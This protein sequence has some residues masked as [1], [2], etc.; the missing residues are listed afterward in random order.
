SPG[1]PDGR[2]EGPGG[3]P[4]MGPSGGFV[5]EK[6]GEAVWSNYPVSDVPRPGLR[7]GNL[8][9]AQRD[10]ATHALQV[11]LSP[12]GYQ[13]VLDI[14]G[15]DQALSDSGTPFASGTAAYTIGI[16]GNPSTTTPWM[17]EFGG[18]HLALNI[19][20]AGK[21]GVITP[22]LT[23]AQPS[24]YT[25]NG[26]TVRVLAQEND[27]A[28]AL[29]NALD[30]TQRNQ[31]ILN[32]RVNDLVLGPG[33]AGVTIQPEGLKASAL[34]EPQRA[35]LLA[36]ISEWAGIINEAYATPRMAEIKAGLDDTYFAWSG[37]ATHEPGKNGSAYYRIQGPKLVIEFSPQGVGGDLTMHVHTMYR[38]PTNDYG[39]KF[40]NIQ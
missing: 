38:D 22:T 10:A 9:G 28:F 27:K 3:G 15:S 21:Q 33:Q 35:M 25:S 36:V 37:P 31:A 6:Y 18:H 29:L 14:M 24:L 5:G 30:E 17:L 23:G 34:N 32:Y 8:N 40:T 4:G 20:I 1:S 39:I 11:L 13:K 2:R 16:F 7:L 26:K 12:K 19:T